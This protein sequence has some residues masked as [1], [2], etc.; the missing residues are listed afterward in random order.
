[1]R[2]RF[3]IV[4][5]SGFTTLASGIFVVVAFELG[6]FI[7]VDSLRK[8]YSLSLSTA[9]H[10]IVTEVWYWH[11]RWFT[12][13][14]VRRGCL[15]LVRF[16]GNMRGHSTCEVSSFCSKRFCCETN[17]GRRFDMR[18]GWDVLIS[19]SVV[20]AEYEKAILRDERASVWGG[21]CG[22]ERT[23]I[24]VTWHCSETKSTSPKFNLNS[25][26]TSCMQF[27]NFQRWH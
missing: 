25:S 5:R 9:V 8:A 6:G 18:F 27:R 11:A 1:M 21:R 15:S 16:A 23:N 4:V 12:L 24:A 14:S 10:F 2:G 20:L 26:P 17:C 22:S 3:V 13:R 7:I 19:W